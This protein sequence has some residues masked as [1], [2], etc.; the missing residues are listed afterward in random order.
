MKAICP[1][2]PHHCSLELGQTG[3]CGGRANVDGAV[4]STNYGRLTSL[5]L[6]P[7]EKKPLQNFYPGSYILSVGSY[8]C[9]L[10]CSFCQNHE[11]SMA[12]PESVLYNLPPEDLIGMAVKYSHERRGN[13]GVAFTYNEPFVSY[14]YVRDC[15]ELLHDVSLKTVLVTNGMIS[16]EPLE[17]ILPLI[18]A[19]NIDLKGFTSAYYD[20]LGGDLETVKAAI[21]QS[22][23]AGCHVEVTTLIVPGKNDSETE[24]EAEA[25]WLASVSRELPL[26][27]SR[28]FPQYQ[29]RDIPETSAE[30]IQR[31]C[32]IAKKHLKYVYAGNC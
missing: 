23:H 24:M 20:W 27:I 17:K 14:E 18:D 11:I 25:A 31:L 1:I 19:M 32:T 21:A 4:V 3:L 26:H 6:D 9:N 12:G 8:G 5:S 15:A 29:V 28:F 10:R 30:T 7:I 2:C 22:M 13:L 16:A